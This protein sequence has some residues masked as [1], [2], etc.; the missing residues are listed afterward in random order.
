MSEK[1]KKKLKAMARI[2]YQA[3]AP[4]VPEKSF[5]EIFNQL[6]HVHKTKSSWQKK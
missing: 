6:K 5:K 4:N 2:F 1:T 3:Q